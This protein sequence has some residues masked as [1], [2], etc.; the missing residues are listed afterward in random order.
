MKSKGSSIVLDEKTE[1]RYLIGRKLIGFKE[2]DRI[3][4]L[5]CYLENPYEDNISYIQEATKLSLYEIFDS[6]PYCIKSIME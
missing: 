3:Y 4:N 5:Q 6:S 1:N 2:D